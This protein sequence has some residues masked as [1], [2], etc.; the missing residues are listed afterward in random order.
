MHS[1]GGLEPIASV[2]VLRVGNSLLR[3]D[4][5]LKLPHRLNKGSGELVNAVFGEAQ[6]ISGGA[7]VLCPPPSIFLP[8][9]PERL[10]QYL[11]Y[12]N[13]LQDRFGDVVLHI[14]PSEGGTVLCVGLQKF[15]RH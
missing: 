3:L 1:R 7:F 8:K 9:G 2:S 11:E 5:C 13:R 6:A 10:P 15:G 4:D 14:N 12:R